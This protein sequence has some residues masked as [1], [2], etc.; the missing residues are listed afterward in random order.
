[1]HAHTNNPDPTTRDNCRR[2]TMVVRARAI[3]IE[4][5]RAC[6]HPAGTDRR[7]SREYSGSHGSAA[8]RCVAT[9]LTSPRLSPTNKHALP[10]FFC[11]CSKNGGGA[12]PLFLFS[13][14]AGAG[15]EHRS[16]AKTKMND[17]SSRSHSLLCVNVIKTVRP[18]VEN[19][20]GQRKRSCLTLI[21]L[22]GSVRS[23]SRRPSQCFARPLRWELCPRM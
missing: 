16:T 7:A 8:R 21:D 2:L 3:R 19:P 12:C 10:S 18:S 13:L 9:L 4:D 14:P 6:V 15:N 11:S 22:A 5:L 1:M 17:L 20:N 23:G